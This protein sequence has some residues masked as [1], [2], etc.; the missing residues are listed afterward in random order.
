LATT[1]D[2]AGNVTT[3]T[4]N[5]LGQKISMRVPHSD[6]AAG[7]WTYEF[8]HF[9]E[10]KR[11][12]NANGHE[13]IMT[14]DGL[15]RIKTRIDKFA[16]GATEGSTTWTYDT[17]VDGLGKLYQVQDAYSGFAKTIM[18]DG[19]GRV[20]EV[21]TNF[22]AG[23]YY[24]KTTYDQYG[25]VYQVFDAAGNGSYTDHGVQN[26]Y[27]SY[28][29]LTAVGD[30]VELNGEPRT[31]YRQI[32]SVN[33]R[34]QVTSEKLG[35][36]TSGDY[37]VSTSF[38]YYA[39]TGRMRDIDAQ[40]MAGNYV[41]DL[42]Y[43]WNDA[44]S[45]TRR[46]DTY[47]DGVSTN[48]LEEVFGYDGLNR[49]TSH[50][51]V[52]QAAL[53]VTYDALGN[54]KTKSGV[55]GTYSYGNNAGP[56]AV[57]SIG[58]QVYTYDDN[59]NNLTG[60]GRTI[61]YS[62]FD[63]P[64]SITK[65]GNTVTFAYSADRSRYRRVDQDTSGTTTTRYIGNVEIIVRPNGTQERKRYIAGTAIETGFYSGGSETSRETIYTLKDHLGSLDVIVG[66]DGQ[67]EQKLSFGPW[68]Q[69]RDASNW[70][71]LN[72]SNQLIDLGP[73]FDT[74]LTKR[75]FTGHEMVDS[76]GI[77]HMNG[78]IY[79]PFI[80]RFLQS[81]N[82]VQDPTNT[83]SH[84]R[85]SYVWN[86]PLNATDPSGEFVFT[87]IAMAAVATAKVAIDW[88]IVAAIFAVAG[89]MDALIAGADLSDAFVSGIIS[90]VSAGAFNGVGNVLGGKLGEKLGQHLLTVKI[91]AH[92]A[93]GGITS[94][95]Q[96]GKFG[97]GFASAAFTAAATSFNSSAHID[98][99]NNG[100]SWKRVAIGAT[101][102]GS[103]SKLSGGKFANGAMTGAFSQAL[104]Y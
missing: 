1:T 34:G 38:T 19:F 52:G 20:D 90:G 104:N 101:I 29:H 7:L 69:R 81:D 55:Q 60:G 23:I 59:G 73:S 45:L 58:S 72:T 74:G 92:G 37:A 2:A 27:G 78:R 32:L 100:F 85:Y 56:H 15:G 57:T 68:G 86:N 83:Q 89:T 43:E 79:D 17:A 42:Y 94:V 49:L 88:Y 64:T 18:Y 87:L 71:E 39:D 65:S 75:G 36:D 30:A 11:Q 96:G 97:H 50:G 99:S 76:V 16:N 22:D 40:D 33:A 91:L 84:N 24:E 67:I 93:I 5:K 28:G 51:E 82:F 31:L 35:V 12:E 62:T 21:V 14:Y 25:R 3:T 46:K 8:N 4:H 103:A 98:K 54:I 61:V 44:G 95:L 13:S 70:E 77:I 9:G 10:M 26:V 48:T 66:E 102:G 41:Q 63:K 47:H 80:G 6:P 53:S